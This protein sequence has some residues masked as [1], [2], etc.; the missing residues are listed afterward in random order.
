MTDYYQFL[1]VLSTT[2]F[3]NLFTY[4]DICAF[5]NVKVRII[6]ILNAINLKY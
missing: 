5:V 1:K 3:C 4:C 2:I 6:L